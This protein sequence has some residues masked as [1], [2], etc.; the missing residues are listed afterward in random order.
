MIGRLQWHHSY[1]V[2]LLRVR[3][4][5]LCVLICAYVLLYKEEYC[6][7][8]LRELMKH[9]PLRCSPRLHL[10]VSLLEQAQGS[11]YE[12]WLSMA[13]VNLPMVCAVQDIGH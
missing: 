7:S 1:L 4:C 5:V 10:P 11:M 2:N 13:R 6:L 9:V 8:K 3:I 12:Y